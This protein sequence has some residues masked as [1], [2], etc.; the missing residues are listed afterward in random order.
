[1]RDLQSTLEV[2]KMPTLAEPKSEMAYRNAAPRDKSY[3]L[4]DGRG[5]FMIVHPD[6]KKFWYFRFRDQQGKQQK[7][8]IKGSYPVVTLKAARDEAARLRELLA[9]GEDP[10]EVSKAKR[11]DTAQQEEARKREHDRIA[12]TFEKVAREWDERFK[13]RRGESTRRA[14]MQRLE[15]DV[16][17]ALG[18]RP[19]TEITA[20]EL[21]KVL[22]RVEQRGRLHTAHYL[23]SYC[24]Q[25]FRFAVASGRMEHDI[26]ADLRGALPPPEEG[27][28]AAILDP[29]AFG[30]LLREI[31]AYQ[32]WFATKYALRLLP[33][34]F[35]RPGELR[36]AQWS[37]ID[38]ERAQWDIPAGRMKMRLPHTVPLSKQVIL[39][40]KELYELSGDGSCLFPSPRQKAMP[41]SNV[42]M[43]N[44][45]R[46]MG[47]TGEEVSAHG[48][49]ATARTLLDERLR[50]NPAY[51]EA[52]LAHRVSDAL[53]TA[54]NRT[55]HL[56]ARRE[57]MQTWADYL[58][59]LK[60]TQATR[61]SKP[62]GPKSVVI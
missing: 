12:A 9:A 42:A 44:G 51:I 17:P 37:E 24:G 26:A 11:L 2:L 58:D 54:Y 25:I 29:I 56:E 60:A 6:G 61:D 38:F 40:L 14:T 57:M 36:L 28:R 34:V 10:R 32:G 22:Q 59:E 53:G 15:K 50:I 20:P 13:G 45:L 33:L 39:V 55:Q 5:L 49:R 30:R 23:L 43:L 52:Q 41:I 47:Y 19:I 4:A 31:D 27:H 1:M 8:A 18:N 21:L 46:R 7:F 3:T 48:F 16:F 35:T 62:L